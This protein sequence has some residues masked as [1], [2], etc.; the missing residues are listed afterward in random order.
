MRNGRHRGEL[1]NLR[2]GDFVLVARE[3]FHQGE[4]LCLRWRGPRHVTQ[5]LSDYA[6]QVEDLQNGHLQTVHG[7]R[8]SF[9]SDASLDTQVILSHVLSSETRM[10]VSRLLKLLDVD[11][12]LFVNVRWKGLGKSEDTME[13]LQRVYED[14]PELLVILLRRK[15]ADATLCGRACVELGLEREVC[16]DPT[17]RPS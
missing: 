6:F 14:V 2:E 16:N 11:G 5:C 1:A 17:G 9:Y 13:P 3:Y 7:T 10:P 4:K 8:L 15:N 12:K